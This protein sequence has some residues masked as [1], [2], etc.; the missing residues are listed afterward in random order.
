MI[1]RVSHGV[2]HG[3]RPFL[4]LL[5]TAAASCDVVF[6]DSVAPESAPFV[7]VTSEPDLSNVGEPVVFGDLLRHQM[8]MVVYNRL[9]FS[10]F[11]IKF[12]GISVPEKK[13]FV[14]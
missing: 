13:I 1:E 14:D 5:P 7:V 3:F 2:G 4:K 11:V 9:F 10:T 8:T 6:S 12:A